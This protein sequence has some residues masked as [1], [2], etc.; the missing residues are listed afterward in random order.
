MKAWHG[1][2]FSRWRVGRLHTN[3]P[4]TVVTVRKSPFKTPEATPESPHIIVERDG[5]EVYDGEIDA[6][7]AF[8]SHDADL[9]DRLTE[10]AADR[11]DDP[12]PL[13]TLRIA[14]HDGSDPVSIRRMVGP[15]AGDEGAL[16]ELLR[17]AFQSV[18]RGWRDN[19]GGYADTEGDSE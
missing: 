16:R 2:S 18:I 19:R 5:T 1:H 7:T 4:Q 6:A 8:R 10:Q 17:G 11:I 3:S 13:V 14:L 9:I 12:T 15:S